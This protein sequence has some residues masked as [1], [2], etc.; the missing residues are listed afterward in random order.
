MIYFP[1]LN[2][3][4]LL[5]QR[6]YTWQQHA[7]TTNE[8]QPGGRRYARAWRTNPLGRWQLGYPHLTDGELATLEGFFGSIAGR[9]GTFTWLD[10]AGNLVQYS[11]DFAQ[12]AWE[13]YTVTVG[14]AVTDPYGG[15]RATSCTGTSANSMLAAAVLPAG[16]ASGFVLC[17]SVWVRAAAPQALS[18][19]FIDSGFTVLGSTTWTLPAGQWLRISHRVTLA[20]NSSIRLLIGG[21]NTWGTVSLDLFGPQVVPMPGPGAYARSPQQWGYHPNC[22]LDTD[23]LSVRHLG[24]NQNSVS[25][26]IAEFAA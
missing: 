25:L 11:E 20:T 3:G 18:I 7:L 8:D 21:F 19:G 9:F 24:P 23:V 26:A 13:K 12:A 10:P 1:Q 2:A 14:S 4:G 5:V 17:G 6:P 22:R 15:S 16:D